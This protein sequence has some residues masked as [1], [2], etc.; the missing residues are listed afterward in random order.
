VKFRRR[1]RLDPSQ[2][3]DRRGAGGGRGGALALGG[4]GLGVV[5]VILVL[6]LSLAGGGDSTLDSLSDLDS[7]DG[8]SAQ[9]GSNTEIASECRT[10]ADAQRT[11]DCRI[12]GTVNSVQAYWKDTLQGYRVVP[13]VF[14]SDFTQTG[15]GGASSEVGPFYCP[16]DQRV[17][18]DLGF[19]EELKSDFGARGGPFAEAYVLAHEYGHHVQNQIGTLDRAGSNDQGPESGSVRVELQADCFAGVWAAHA[20]DTRYLSQVSR[21]DIAQAL[22]AASAVGDDRIQKAA[23]GAVNPETWTHGSS[24]ERQRWFQTGYDTG[25]PNQC[26]TFGG[27]I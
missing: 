25:S 12:L 11:Q 7:L 22:D 6:V 20:V 2:V 16:A 27:S 18:I 4:G 26:D 23:Q 19:F 9:P 5:G 8:V 21:N 24:A 13:T 1:A 10:G 15:C 3:Q 14:F 17:Y